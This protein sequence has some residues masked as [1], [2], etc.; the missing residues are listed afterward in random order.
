MDDFMLDLCMSLFM[1]VGWQLKEMNLV[2]TQ[3]HHIFPTN[4]YSQESQISMEEGGGGEE[5]KNNR[6]CFLVLLIIPAV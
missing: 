5:K 6:H 1:S 4:Y 2:K 3:I